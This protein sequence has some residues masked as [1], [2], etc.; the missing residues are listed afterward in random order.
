LFGALFLLIVVQEWAD[1]YVEQVAQHAL[2]QGV[3]FIVLVAQE[4]IIVHF[5]KP[6]SEIF[7]YQEVVAE[8]LPA[9]LSLLLIYLIFDCKNSVNS[10]ILHRGKHVLLDVNVFAWVFLVQKLLKQL[11]GNRIADFVRSKS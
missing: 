8:K 4:R 6:G 1:C 9:I 3:L 11:E 5:E 10:D 2:Q 7:I